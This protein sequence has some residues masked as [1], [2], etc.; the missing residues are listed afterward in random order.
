MDTSVDRRR[1]LQL[2]AA[3]SLAFWVG[4]ERADADPVPE[5]KLNIGCI[6]CGGR[7]AGDI[8]GVA[9][10]NIIALCDVDDRQIGGAKQRFPNAKVYRDYRR[11]LE[12][13][14]EIEAVTVATP[15]HSHAAATAMAMRLGK[16]VYTEKP[17]TR[18]VHEA[19]TVRRLA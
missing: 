15:D 19:R 14:P 10:E 6:G 18:T 17:L 9:G 11:M 4:S 8:D 2:G 12:E 5:Q 16:H 13:M 1:F 7:G 3:S